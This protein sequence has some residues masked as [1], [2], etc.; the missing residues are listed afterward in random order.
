MVYTSKI[1]IEVLELD[2]R[3]LITSNEDKVNNKVVVLDNIDNFY[4][5]N[6]FIWDCLECNKVYNI[7][8]EIV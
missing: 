1:L 2:L 5:N 3:W 4:V 6:F 7:R 8:L